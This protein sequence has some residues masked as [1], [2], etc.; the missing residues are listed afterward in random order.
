[1]KKNI[2]DVYVPTIN[3]EVTY[4]YSEI[5][6][7]MLNSIGICTEKIS[8]IEKNKKCRE[9]IFVVDIFDVIKA[10]FCGYKIIIFWM[11]GVPAEESYMRNK[12]RLRRLI[13]R[14]IQRYAFSKVNFFL[15]VS[16][17]MQQYIK[18]YGRRDIKECSYVM[19]CFNEE[20]KITGENTP[21]MKTKGNNFV[22][23]GGLQKWQNYK[24]ILNIFSIVNAYYQDSKLFVYTQEVNEARK[25]AEELGVKVEEISKLS[26]EEVSD[27]IKN[28]KFGFVIRD[29][30]IVNNVSTPTKLS[31][32]L[33]NKIIPIYTD[34]L[35]G[36]MNAMR[37]KKYQIMLHA[38]DSEKEM[39]DRI[40]ESEL[41]GRI[42][43]AELDREYSD[44]FNR[45]YSKEHH[46]QEG[47]K[48]IG[49][50]LLLDAKCK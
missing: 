50:F 37:G 32:Y 3:S 5:V 30:N 20:L 15:C 36:F 11:Q 45:Y 2:F 12:S 17:S 28:I 9:G 1:M 33:A 26:P 47:G 16:E 41:M 13:L 18:R 6:N 4:F 21:D 40:L 49:E 14:I 48:K 42:D 38:I 29:N 23:V 10:H 19:P 46:I 25:I 8:K 7:S 31:N 27:K 24:K 43:Y 34:S 44:V 39:A 22:Y 35:F